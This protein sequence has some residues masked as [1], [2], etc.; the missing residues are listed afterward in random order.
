MKRRKRRLPWKS[1]TA[2]LVVAVAVAIAYFSFMHRPRFYRIALNDPAAGDYES[3]HRFEQSMAD[4]HNALKNEG[5][6]QIQLVDS[7]LNS[8]LET[9]QP[10]KLPDLIPKELRHPRVTIDQR[11]I[12]IACE[13]DWRGV[14][15]VLSLD[16]EVFLTEEPNVIGLKVARFRCG[17]IP[18]P[19]TQIADTISEV[20]NEAGFRIRW[21]QDSGK[22]L[23]LVTVP[24][25]W[26][27]NDK[28]S[29]QIKRV[30]TLEKTL[31]VNGTTSK[32]Q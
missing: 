25:Q 10:Q 17:A 29:L 12:R 5:D 28:H 22:P 9:H 6:W 18:L 26:D 30:E 8:W 14:S 19:I 23:A 3:G 21:T 20:A 11:L 31:L 24:E 4:I 13:T 2:L 27:D 7:E 15:V 32:Q 1:L 16:F